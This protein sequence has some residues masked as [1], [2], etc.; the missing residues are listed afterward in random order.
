MQ[1]AGIDFF[2]VMLYLGGIIFM[3]LYF[4]KYVQTST[5]YFL[6]GKAASILGDRHVNSCL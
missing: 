1:L 5:D 2:I 3:G 6:A 4:R